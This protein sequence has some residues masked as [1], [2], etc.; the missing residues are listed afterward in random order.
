M[1][2]KAPENM[3]ILKRGAMMIGDI[4]VI[5]L[6]AMMIG[7]ERDLLAGKIKERGETIKSLINMKGE[8]E[9][10]VEAMKEDK[11]ENIDRKIIIV[12]VI[13]TKTEENISKEILVIANMMKEDIGSEMISMIVI[14]RIEKTIEET[15]ENMTNMI[16]I[17]EEI[18]II[19]VNTKSQ[20]IYKDTQNKQVGIRKKVIDI[21]KNLKDM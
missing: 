1:I 10:E 18:T 12:Q 6:I 17:E 19:Q 15:M 3:M 4:Q 9:A 7:T 16:K 21:K 8:E 14:I 20:K 5:L 13:G 2:R 11:K